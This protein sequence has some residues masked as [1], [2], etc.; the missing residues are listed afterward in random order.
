MNA[1]TIFRKKIILWCNL[2]IEHFG[3][4]EDIFFSQHL[5]RKKSFTVARNGD[6]GKHRVDAQLNH[7]LQKQV[8]TSS[9][10]ISV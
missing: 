2:N 10:I 8:N 1:K 9:F 3:S 7:S 5:L 4:T 6:N